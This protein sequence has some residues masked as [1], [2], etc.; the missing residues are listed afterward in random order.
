MWRKGVASGT[1]GLSILPPQE[2]YTLRETPPPPLS[3]RPYEPGERRW[4]ASIFCVP[5]GEN[6]LRKP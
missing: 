2:F 6:C 1:A 5:R 4:A 3:G